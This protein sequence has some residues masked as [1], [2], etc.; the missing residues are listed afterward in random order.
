MRVW[1]SYFEG[2][3][4]MKHNTLYFVVA[5]AVAGCGITAQDEGAGQGSALSGRAIDG[6]LAGSVVFVDTNE[7]GVLEPW[8]PRAITDENGY[9]SYNPLTQ[10]NY[11]ALEKG[12]VGSEFCLRAP[13]GYEE[14][15][16]KVVAGYDS[17]FAAPF[18]GSMILRAQM[19]EDIT[20]LMHGSPLTTLL[21]Y[22]SAQEKEA[23][24]A[25]ETAADSVDTFTEA[26]YNGD[27]LSD[28]NE[29]STAE[30]NRKRIKLV[31]TAIQAHKVADLIANYLASKYS[32]DNGKA[33]FGE[34][35]DFPGEAT[36]FVYRAIA[37]ELSQDPAG[38]LASLLSDANRMASV[39]LQ[40]Q[41][42]I[43]K[44]ID[45][46]NGAKSENDPVVS[47]ELA[48]VTNANERVADFAAFVASVFDPGSA[49]VG[50]NEGENIKARLRAVEIVTRLLRDPATI[51]AAVMD[52]KAQRAMDLATT[53]ADAGTYLANLAQPQAHVGLITQRFTDSA[54]PASLDASVADLS[55]RQT[56]V[57]QITAS[58][59]NVEAGEDGLI[60]SGEISMAKNNDGGADQVSL[61]LNE[62]GTL[63]ADI[64]FNG[65]EGSAL[66][67]D[68]TQEGEPLTGSWSQNPDDPYTIYANVEVA[69]VLQP[70]IITTNADGT[71]YQFDFGGE[72][73]DW[74]TTP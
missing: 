38:G 58:G 65:G 17:T 48:A 23:Y 73:V 66:N 69:G 21:S 49:A 18:E 10:T 46:Y 12:A 42:L 54:N 2:A 24:L 33:L 27:F 68:T 71:G 34:H 45:S 13:Q 4:K 8:E 37:G 59:G 19:Q 32:F 55:T 20:Q 28:F 63:S 61:V 41:N 50:S 5:A 72:L 25:A 29:L 67:V 15:L 43:N 62:D 31:R 44:A 53:A 16:L 60:K 1:K 30:E 22:M 56:A 9:F 39:I 74:S 64:V 52:A 40:A 11:C 26:D 6:Y 57:E 36:Q 14:V 35:K 51:D 70:V 3:E 47:T 7:N